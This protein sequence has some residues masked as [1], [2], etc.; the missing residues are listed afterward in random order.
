[1]VSTD[2]DVDFLWPAIERLSS[3]HLKGAQLIR[4]CGSFFSEKKTST[5]IAHTLGIH[6]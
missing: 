3:P 2:D 6:Q 4:L 1:L 5:T